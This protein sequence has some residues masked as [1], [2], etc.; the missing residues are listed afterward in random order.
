MEIAV[1]GWLLLPGIVGFDKGLMTK[2]KY[3]IYFETD[4]F[5]HKEKIVTQ[6]QI[7]CLAI[8]HYFLYSPFDG[9]AS[10]HSATLKMIAS[11]KNHF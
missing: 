8:G 2:H 3:R 5:Q 11:D 10:K 7:I 6:W 1:S 4:S 9:Q